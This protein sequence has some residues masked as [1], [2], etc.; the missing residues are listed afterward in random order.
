MRSKHKPKGANAIDRGME[1][2]GNGWLV[3]LIRGGITERAGK[4]RKIRPI[5]VRDHRKEEE[6]EC[7]NRVFWTVINWCEVCTVFMLSIIWRSRVSVGPH[8]DACLRT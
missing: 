7:F 6:E 4:E 3:S 2:D 5:R 8:G 1:D